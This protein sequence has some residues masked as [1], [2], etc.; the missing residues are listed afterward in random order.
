MSLTNRPL[1]LIAGVPLLLLGW[2]L[3]CAAQFPTPGRLDFLKAHDSSFALMAN[4][5]STF[6]SGRSYPNEVLLITGLPFSPAVSARVDL[7]LGDPHCAAG[8]PC[9]RLRNIALSPDG[10]TAL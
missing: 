7:G 1:K 5:S 10:D 9:G 2:S 4:T 8:E 6:Q 3:P